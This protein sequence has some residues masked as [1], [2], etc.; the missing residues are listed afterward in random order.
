MKNI[1]LKNF[2]FGTAMVSGFALGAASCSQKDKDNSTQ[3]ET[4]QQTYST[5]GDFKKRMQELTPQVMLETILAEGVELDD[6]GLC[7]PYRKK[8][9]DGTWDKWTIG[10]GLT[11]LDGEPVTG[12]TRHITLKEAWEKSVNFYENEE[13]YFFMWCYEIGI[14]SLNINTQEKALGLASVMYNTNTSCIENKNDK[15]HCNRNQKLRDLYKM[16]GDTVTTDQVR[17]VF[18][19]Y[20]VKNN[21]SFCKALNGGTTEDW[22][23]TLGNFCAEKG[24]IYWRRWLQGQ[25]AMGNITYKDLLDLPIGSMYEFWRIIG[26]DK[27]ALFDTN[28]DGSAVVNPNGIKKFKQWVKNPVTKE[29]LPNNHTT[30]RQLLNSI[31]PELVYQAEHGMF[32]PSDLD[33]YFMDFEEIKHKYSCNAQNDTSYI[34]YQN[35]DYDKALD[36]GKNALQMA[37]TNKQK[38]AAT[39]NIGISYLAKGK[40]DKAKKYLTQS[41]AYNKTKAAEDALK[42]VQEKRQERNKKAGRDICLALTIGA[43]IGAVANKRKKYIMQR[44][45]NR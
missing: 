8:L 44:Q 30:V 42:S 36:A 38:G 41:N 7:K 13:T 11:Y 39:Y 16:Y 19:Q 26:A 45:N 28:P 32:N 35:G 37:E 5:Y 27:S 12:N 23:N 4:T 15:D 22:A 34:A 10:F 40:Y 33:I 29:G 21:Y 20:P 9:S 18:A 31:N 6:K 25:I 24:G 17:A 3:T 2:L 1:R 43:A 14:D